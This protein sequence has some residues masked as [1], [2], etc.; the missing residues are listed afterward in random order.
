MTLD[1]TLTQYMELLSALDGYSI[2]TVEE[3]LRGRGAEPFAV[4]RHDV[5]LFPERAARMAR[6]ERGVNIRATY[7][8]R[9]TGA[10]PREATPQVKDN[11]NTVFKS[12]GF[13]VKEIIE[14]KLH[15]H[16][17]GYHYENLSMIGDREMALRDFEAKLTELRKLAPVSTVAM[18]GSPL[19]RVCNA[20]LLRGIDLSGY[21]LLGDPHISPEFNDVVYITDTGRRWSSGETS[22]RDR[23]GRPVSEKIKNT[24]HLISILRDMRYPNLMINAHP[25][26]WSA[27]RREWT[28]ELLGQRVRNVGK[29]VLRTRVR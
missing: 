5:D 22:V 24:Q 7:Y 20:D 27:T 6:L 14:V 23:L 19:S 18:H 29:A 13:P 9:W 4:L 11:S 12:S 25:Q 8:F 26:R 16:E 21:G 3:F 28:A 15:R 2:V 1:F 10:M 17:V